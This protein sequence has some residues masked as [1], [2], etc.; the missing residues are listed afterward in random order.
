M[1]RIL[2]GRLFHITGLFDTNC[3]IIRFQLQIVTKQIVTTNSVTK[4]GKPAIHAMYLYVPVCTCMHPMFVM[5]TIYTKPNISINF[6]GYQTVL[7]TRVHAWKTIIKVC[8]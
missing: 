4:I 8:R 5:C 6:T 1:L 7:F 3:F 2:G